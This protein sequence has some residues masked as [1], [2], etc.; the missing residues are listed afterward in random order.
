[1]PIGASFVEA[2]HQAVK[3]SRDLIILFTR[4]Y[5]ESPYT[6]HH[7]RSRAPFPGSTTAATTVHWGAATNPELHGSY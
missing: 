2:M 6:P 5:E 7:C 4:D 3:N 1:M